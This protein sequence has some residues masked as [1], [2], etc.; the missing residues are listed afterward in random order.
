MSLT[1]QDLKDIRNVVL[2]ALEVAVIPRLDALEAEVAA[3]K[4]EVASFKAETSR[5]L[6]ALEAQMKNTNGRLTALEN[7]VKELYHMI[8]KKPSFGFGSKEYQKLPS[9][10]KIH[11]LDHEVGALAKDMGVTLRRSV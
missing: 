6:D 4:S 1:K 2:E 10:D 7:D 11:I 8:D 3:L 9:E 5:R